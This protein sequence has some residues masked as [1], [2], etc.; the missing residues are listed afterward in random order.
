MN[1]WRKFTYRWQDLKISIDLRIDEWSLK[2]GGNR[3]QRLS[4]G[5]SQQDIEDYL[6]YL[7]EISRT[8]K[9]VF[10]KEDPVVHYNSDGLDFASNFLMTW[11]GYKQVTVQPGWFTSSLIA[12]R[13]SFRERTA[14]LPKLLEAVRVELLRYGPCARASQVR[15]AVNSARI[16]MELQDQANAK[17][18]L[19]MPVAVKRWVG[20]RFSPKCFPIVTEYN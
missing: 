20:D 4:K 18:I 19:N 8:D 16:R 6:D 5:V 17:T 13:T 15:S 10:G 11:R 12:F 1:L 2:H 9:T 7:I 14:P 3:Q